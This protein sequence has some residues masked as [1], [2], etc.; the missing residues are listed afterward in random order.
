MFRRE[1]DVLLL[2]TA[3]AEPLLECRIGQTAFHASNE[4]VAWGKQ[5]AE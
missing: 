5:G 3:M 2:G 1:G 4:P